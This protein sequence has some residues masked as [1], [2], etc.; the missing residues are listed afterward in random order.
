MTQLE[1]QARPRLP[2]RVP[3]LRDR[4]AGLDPI[5]GLLEQRLVVGV[6]PAS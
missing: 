3:D 6:E 4:L 1:V 2:A 5:A